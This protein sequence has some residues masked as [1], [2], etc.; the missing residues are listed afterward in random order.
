MFKKFVSYIIIIN[1]QHVSNA[2]ATVKMIRRIGLISPVPHCCNDLRDRFWSTLTYALSEFRSS[3]TPSHR[4]YFFRRSIRY[5]FSL[6]HVIQKIISASVC[7][8]PTLFSRLVSRVFRSA[9]KLVLPAAA[10][11]ARGD[12]GDD[13]IALRPPLP[14]AER[15][16]TVGGGL[17]RGFVRSVAVRSERSWCT[18]TVCV[19]KNTFFVFYR[20]TSVLEPFAVGTWF[21]AIFF[22]PLATRAIEQLLSRLSRGT[23]ELRSV[24]EQ[25]P[26][27]RPPFKILEHFFFSEFLLTIITLVRIWTRIII[28]ITIQPRSVL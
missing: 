12:R 4:G 24:D 1:N 7:L 11:S 10:P 27:S 2:L 13:F 15:A 16:T 20:S 3:N 28:I 19:N 5:V 14:R 26:F 17:S 18:F 8:F 23:R 22:S 9:K 25:R 21:L 6:L